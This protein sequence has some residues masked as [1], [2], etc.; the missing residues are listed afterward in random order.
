MAIEYA[1]IVDAPNFTDMD[2]PTITYANPY[3]NSATSLQACIASADG[4]QV[5]VPYRDINKTG[6]SYTFKLTTDERTALRKYVTSGYSKSIAFYIWTK[7]NGTEK[8][9]WKIKTLTLVDADPLVSCI[10]VDTNPITSNL[11]NNTRKF[12]YGESD[13]Y[14]TVSAAGRKEGIVSSYNVK[15]G[16]YTSTTKTGTIYNIMPGYQENYITVTATDNRGNS[17]TARAELDIVWY[18]RPE[19]YLEE[20]SLSTSSGNLYFNVRC[21][22]FDGYFDGTTDGS[23]HG[24]KNEATL[25]YRYK[26]EDGEYSEWF[27]ADPNGI[28]YDTE[29][30]IENNFNEYM[31]KVA[32]SGLDYTSTYKVQLRLLD[33]VV[34]GDEAAVSEEYTMRMIPVFDWSREDFAVNVPTR[35]NDG[36]YLRNN[37]GEHSQV[38]QY[39]GES[40]DFPLGLEIGLDNFI[41]AIDYPDSSQNQYDTTVYGNS[42]MNTAVNDIYLTPTYGKVYVNFEPL[43]DFVIEQG[44]SDGWFYRLWNSGIA[45]CW[46]LYYENGVNAA[47]TH[48]N[49]FYY[50]SGIQVYFPFTFTNLPTVT[51]DGGSTAHMNFVRK[52]GN[53]N[54]HVNFVVVGLAS[55]ATNVNI[56]VDIRAIGKWR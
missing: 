26:L 10:V 37:E 27:N 3:G 15:F 22:W 19:C 32:I 21:Y 36:L 44:E 18:M 9:N 14:Y 55:D 39:G 42:I 5:L 30:Y 51:L 11:T 4:K 24:E 31:W 12:I 47:A 13:A 40:A 46:K 35:L 56:T 6:T 8:G 34:I 16:N 17:D 23:E 20:D 43:N 33:K 1:Y 45:E 2:N 25:Q 48:Y 7:V 41:D 29:N 52:F 28:S 53:Y 50:S 54:N 38:M 49:G